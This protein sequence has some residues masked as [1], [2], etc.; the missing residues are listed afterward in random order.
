MF[1]GYFFVSST[2]FAPFPDLECSRITAVIG[3]V[4]FLNRRFDSALRSAIDKQ[5][6]MKRKKKCDCEIDLQRRCDCEI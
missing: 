6:R 2:P 3:S 5:Y 4:L 1:V